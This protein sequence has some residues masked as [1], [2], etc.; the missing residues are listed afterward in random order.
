MFFRAENIIQSHETID[1]VP[2][3]VV[4]FLLV[5]R[6]VPVVSVSKHKINKLKI[7]LGFKWQFY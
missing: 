4:N 1:F 7:R 6:K 3:I 5:V 2:N